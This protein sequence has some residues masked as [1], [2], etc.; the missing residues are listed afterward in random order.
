[1]WIYLVNIMQTLVLKW[2]ETPNAFFMSDI[3]CCYAVFTCKT[4][5]LQNNTVDIVHRRFGFGSIK[6]LSLLH[7]QIDFITAYFGDIKV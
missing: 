1:M 7:K 3:Y 5:H 6:V 2:N 4:V